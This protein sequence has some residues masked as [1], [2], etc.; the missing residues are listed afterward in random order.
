MDY[1]KEIPIF[2]SLS[3]PTINGDWTSPRYNGCC[4]IEN[5]IADMQMYNIKK[6]FAVGIKNTGDYDE[7]KFI[8]MVL[9]KGDDLFLPI[10]FFDFKH[11]SIKE[12]HYKL[13]EIKEKGYVGIKLHPRIGE[14]LLSDKRLPYIIDYSNELDL[15]PMLCTFFYCNH[16][17]MLENNIDRLSELLL[18]CSINSDIILVH[19]GLTRVLETME[20]VRFFPNAVL[21]LSLTMCKYEGS[22]LDYD[23]EYI[24]KFFDR[25]TIIGTDSPEVNHQ[26]LR[27]RFD[28]FAS[29]TTIEKAENIAYKNIEKVLTKHNIK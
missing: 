25:R 26:T 17:S 3:H 11:L 23:I 7:N 20:L 1:I 15:L 18:S 9:N 21:D 2:D 27:R 5:M 12:I 29:K 24:F 28:Y 19:G 4:R 14:F 16:Q 8:H 10:A 6:A 22:H 13:I